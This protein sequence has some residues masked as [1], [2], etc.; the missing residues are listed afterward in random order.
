MAL[1]R[2]ATRLAPLTVKGVM[3]DQVQT[4][5]S[6]TVKNALMVHRVINVLEAKFYPKMVKLV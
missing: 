3:G 4:A 2:H 1:V 6:R 5:V